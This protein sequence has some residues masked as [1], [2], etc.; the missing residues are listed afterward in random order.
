MWHNTIEEI[1]TS[2]LLF[3]Q[4]QKK[5]HN[6]KE[7]IYNNNGLLP[8]IISPPL[9]LPLSLIVA[10]GATVRASSPSRLSFV[11]ASPHTFSLAA[12]VRSDPHH[13]AAVLPPS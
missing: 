10:A 13:P 2:K 1:K 3:I 7:K 4:Q 9:L 12:I 5:E 6:I 8:L 11:T